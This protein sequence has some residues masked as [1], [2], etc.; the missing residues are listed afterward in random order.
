MLS[1][2]KG[3]KTCGRYEPLYVYMEEIKLTVY[4]QKDRI[5]GNQ[6]IGFYKLFY[7]HIINLIIVRIIS[8]KGFDFFVCDFIQEK[9]NFCPFCN[10]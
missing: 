9:C 6:H 5:F 2:R 10:W 7:I 4:L 3:T 1:N 8:S